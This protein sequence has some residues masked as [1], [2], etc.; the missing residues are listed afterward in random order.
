M[1]IKRAE[2]LR[3]IAESIENAF[4]LPSYAEWRRDIEE[5]VAWYLHNGGKSRWTIGGNVFF[6]NSGHAL[7]HLGP[8]LLCEV[9]KR[10]NLNTAD[11]NGMIEQVVELGHPIG[12]QECVETNDSDSIVYLQRSGRKRQSRFAIGRSPEPCSTVFIVLR[13]I[14]T[15]Q[16]VYQII[17]S[18][19]GTKSGKEPWDRRAT[20]SDAEFWRNHALVS[21]DEIDSSED[22]GEEGYWTRMVAES[23]KNNFYKN[24]KKNTAKISEST[25]K[26]MISESIKAVL[27]EDY[28]DDK[29]MM[30]KTPSRVM[31]SADLPSGY[32]ELENPY[33]P[34][35]KQVR[36]ATDAAA[37]MNRI[38]KKFV[39]EAEEANESWTINSL[40]QE[41][42]SK[43]SRLNGFQYNEPHV[44]EFPIED[45]QKRVAAYVK[46]VYNNLFYFEEN[47]GRNTVAESITN[48][49]KQDG[50]YYGNDSAING[51]KGW[52]VYLFKDSMTGEPAAE[53]TKANLKNAGMHINSLN[54]L[55][56]KFFAKYEDAVKWCQSKGIEKITP[57]DEN[58][59]LRIDTPETHGYD[60]NEPSDGSYEES[61]RRELIDAAKRSA[62]DI[63][64]K[65]IRGKAGLFKP[66]A[67][68]AFTYN[69]IADGMGR[70]IRSEEAK[71]KLSEYFKTGGKEKAVRGAIY[72]GF[73]YV[74]Q[75][76]KRKK[77]YGY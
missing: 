52:F 8:T 25:L 60:Y 76:L 44:Y 61:I 49:F 7:C 68:I 35:A 71:K 69:K 63:A 27:R 51:K 46:K 65:E 62:C 26:K 59:H 40:A 13:K 6:D 3:I 31:P 72:G 23:I 4:H 55:P 43:F 47:G 75:E 33:I 22:V 36:S 30:A 57:R 53:I 11:K 20:D 1:K 32:G 67:T 19:V 64:N 16:N 39:Y 66:G 54:G 24:M 48:Y 70:Y 15:A 56:K 14:K 58:G 5:E 74:E 45:I 2:L 34:T 28:F 17:T 12:Y 21:P 18:Y 42:F 37:K 77:Q 9:L 29:P 38:V 73:K 50:D 10:V 41:I